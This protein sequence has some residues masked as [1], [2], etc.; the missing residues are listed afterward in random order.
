MR[1]CKTNSQ[2]LSSCVSAASRLAA[3]LNSSWI[4]IILYIVGTK[5][6]MIPTPN[7]FKEY[8][9]KFR[10]LRSFESADGDTVTHL[11]QQHIAPHL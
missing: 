8:A 9:E 2:S 10:N 4:I 7:L 11:Q 3:K 1:V 5:Y 6:T